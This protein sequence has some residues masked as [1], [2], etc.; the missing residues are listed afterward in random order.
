MS[1][2]GEEACGGRDGRGD[3]DLAHR[4]DDGGHFGN[5]DRADIDGANGGHFETGGL[6]GR[7]GK[8][9]EDEG[10]A[11]SGGESKV[12]HGRLL[13]VIDASNICVLL[14]EPLWVSFITIAFTKLVKK[15]HPFGWLF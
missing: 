6:S 7:T 8:A 13:F 12:T 10:A 14:W 9:Q 5:M 15:I 2:G 1:L 4:H 11:S 3:D